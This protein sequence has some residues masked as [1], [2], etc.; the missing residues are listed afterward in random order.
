MP[1]TLFYTPILLATYLLSTPHLEAVTRAVDNT[2]NDPGI[3]GTLP[4]WLLNANNGDI[5]DCDSIAGQSITLTSSLPAITKSYTIQGAGITIDGANSY[6]AFQVAS[7]VVEINNIIVQNAISK[8]GD[9]GDGYSGGGGA[10]GGG[11]ALYVHGGASVTLT[12]SSLLNNTAQGGNGGSASNIGN[13][14]AGGGGG[15]GGGNGGSSLSGVSTG[16]G[17]GGHSNGGNGGSGSAINGSNGVYF[18]GGGGGAGINSVAAGGN[19]GNASPSG[20][21]IGGAEANGNGGGGAGTS[22]NGDAATGSGGAGIPG[23]GGNGIGSDLLF[24]GGGGGGCAS[25]TGFPGAIG[26]GSAGGGGGANYSGGAGG[27]LGGGGGGGLGGVGGAGGFGAGGGGAVT[28]G[29]GGGGFNAGGGNGASDPGGNNGA[30]GGG[31]GLGG[32]IFIQSG[33]SLTILDAVQI[34]DNTS[35]AG[36]GGSSTNSS[37]PNYVAPGN[38]LAL[39]S[40]IFLREQG[41][42]TF[43]LSNTLTMAT[44]IEGDQTSGPMT[45]GGLNKLGKGSL[46]LNG[47]NTYSGTTVID[48]GTLNLNGSVVGNAIVGPEGTFA[49]NATVFGTLTN[50]GVLT[51]GNSIGTI[52]TTNLVLNSSSLLEIEIA[53]GGTNDLLAAT[54]TAQLAGTLKMDIDPNA[55]LGSYTLLSSSGI[56]GSFDSIFF[57]NQTPRYALSYLPNGAPTYVQLD[58]LGFPLSTEGLFGNNLRTANYLNTLAISPELTEQ[59]TLLNELSSSQYKKAL[60]S[61]NPSRNASFTFT[62]QNLMFMFSSTL[63]SHFTNRRLTHKQAKTLPKKNISLLTDNELLTTNP[64]PRN[65]ISPSSTQNESQ[66]WAM[67]FGA[68]SHQDSQNQTP[69]F[70]FNSGG[71]FVAYDYGNT[72]QGCIGTLAGYAHSSIQENQSMGGGDLNAGFLSIYGTSSFSDFFLDAAIWGQLMGVDQERNISFPGFEETAQSSFRAGQLDLHFGTGYDFKIKTGIIEPFGM[73][74][75]VYQWDPTYSERGAAP[76]NMQIASRTSWMLRLE[77][78]LNGYHTI[79]FDS[80]IFVVRA[81]L[82]Y[83]YKKPHNVGHLDAAIVG[84]PTS[85][86]VEAFTTHQSLVSPAAELF[87]K[88][89]WNGYASLVYDGEFGSGYTSNQIYARIGVFF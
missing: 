85:F 19:G 5:I 2:S 21:F 12:V 18:G 33:G 48:G 51:P 42:I 22:E 81:K 73:L 49:G 47:E 3:I 45:T 41:S 24:G 27:V 40:D 31:S 87:W 83:V 39:G 11:G 13:A 71:F 28:G 64:F 74:D 30:G 52:H 7:G 38:G 37:D 58:F 53:S 88:T 66:I 72:D 26:I 55:P 17:G 65:V 57:V 61:I 44:P 46:Q 77:T 1:K 4:Y 14:G 6:Q 32:A 36:L 34:S 63:D 68:F 43:N 20:M 50:S 70:H 86:F 82:S 84:A 35:L 60:E 62:A 8:G 59:F 29:T 23:E 75:W 10:V 89:N 16:G 9:G 69:A 78:G 25:E 15:F 56:T 67:G 54:G 76:Y 80:G 79:T